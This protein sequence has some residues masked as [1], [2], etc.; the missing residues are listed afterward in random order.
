MTSLA[1]SVAGQVPVK[2]TGTWQRHLPAR[3]LDRAMEGR[4]SY[5]R[6]GRD[7]GFPVLYLGRP[8]DS[9]VVEA[10]RHL[11]DPVENGEELRKQLAPRVLVAAEVEVTEILDL[12]RSST[13]MQ[14]GLSP[15]SVT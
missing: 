13:R 3:W 9:I 5:S 15:M 4:Q 7:R 12:R 8:Q 10:Y 11:I 14:I 2:I 1:N 6:W